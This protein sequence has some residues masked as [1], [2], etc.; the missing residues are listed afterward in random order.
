[1]NFNYFK[2]PNYFKH[3]NDDD[4]DDECLVHQNKPAAKVQLMLHTVQ[5]SVARFRWMCVSP[6]QFHRR[7]FRE[8]GEIE[9]AHTADSSPVIDIVQA[10]R[11]RTCLSP[12]HNGIDPVY[13]D[14]DS[15]TVYRSIPAM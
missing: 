12:R 3:S 13:D 14:H 7:R 1:M 9:A 2:L 11:R 6:C 10:Y 4:D 8:S 15:Y 5:L